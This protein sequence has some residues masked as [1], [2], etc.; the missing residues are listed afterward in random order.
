[1]WK[2]NFVPTSVMLVCSLF[3]FILLSWYASMLF[4]G[5]IP[6]H[7][8]L[9]RGWLRDTGYPICCDSGLFVTVHHYSHYSRLL[10][11]SVLFAIRYSRLFAIGCSWL[12][13]IWVFQ[14]PEILVNELIFNF[15]SKLAPHR[16][17]IILLFS[18][19]AYIINSWSCFQ[20]YDCEAAEGMKKD[21]TET[22]LI[23]HVAQN[24]VCR[25]GFWRFF[26]T[27]HAKKIFSTK[28]K[29][30]NPAHFFFFHFVCKN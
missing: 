5:K 18:P 16:G 4:S 3:T 23:Y 17:K 24:P 14:T 10:A 8:K 28:K 22:Q 19:G 13:A 30:K 1:M 11:L 7:V 6:S 12:Y 27:S 21:G 26:S 25:F 9:L 29:K 20:S 2:V 15:V